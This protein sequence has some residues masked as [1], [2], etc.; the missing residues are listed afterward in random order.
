MKVINIHK[1]DIA[2]PKVELERLFRTLATDNDLMLATE[3]WSPMK[4]DKGLIVGSKGGHG[5]IKYFVAEFQS[6]KSVTFQFDLSGFDGF[7]RFELSEIGENATEL[8]HTIDMTTTGAATIK[9][10]LAVRWLHDAYIEDAFDKV[11]NHFVDDKKVSPWNLW[12]KILRK[13]MK[14]K[15]NPSTL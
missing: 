1:R 9:W 4:L 13:A 11:E 3:K 6:D 2:R 5:P 7:H 14:P 12:V 10:I 8:K 15:R